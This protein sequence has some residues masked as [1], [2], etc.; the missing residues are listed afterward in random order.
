VNGTTSGV[1]A[2]IIEVTATTT[3]LKLILPAATQVSTGQSFLIKNVGN[4]NPFTV[5]KSDGTTTIVAINSGIAYYVYLT[6]N[7]TTNGTWA[8]VQFGASTSV[9]NASSLVGYGLE[10]VGTTLNTVT[11]FI[12]YYSAVTLTA[13]AQSQISVWGGGA[14]TITL[15]QSAVVG[16][17]WYTIIKN[18]GTGILT[19]ATQGTDTID[20]YT[21]FQLQIG[22]SFYL[23]SNGSG[24]ASWGY[25]QSAVFAFTQEQI[26][27]TGA[28]STITLTGTQASYVLQNFTGT[29]SQ[30]TN[31]IVPQTVQ[32]YVITNSTTGAFT[33]TFKTSVGGGATVVVPT[34]ITYAI[35]CDGTNMIAV[36]SST[37]ASN[38]ITLSAG[39]ATNPPLNFVG[40]LNTGIYLPSSAQLGITVGGSQEAVFSSS[41][42][43][44]VNGISGGTF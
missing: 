22:E 38:S 30:N 6:D 19:V 31:V 28:G 1:V 13:T 4:T 10:A 14:G 7:T 12:E 16:S 39:S 17:S 36:S 29:L 18:N 42:L 40:N 32:F 21:T 35:V 9:A 34:G 27:V 26:S 5:V 24:F 15:P 41:G 25:G 2:N 3:G 23:V 33:L 20:G 43:Y 11:P 44:V 37:N 8:F